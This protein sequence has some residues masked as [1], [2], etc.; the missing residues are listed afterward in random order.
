MANNIKKIKRID[1]EIENLKGHIESLKETRETMF[2]KHIVE[3]D[4][5]DELLT[6]AQAAR[7]FSKN[8]LTVRNLYSQKLDHLRKK[9]EER[10]YRISYGDLKD[11][12]QVNTPSR[13]DHVS[14]RKLPLLNAIEHMKSEGM[15]NRDIAAVLDCSL[16]MVVRS[17]AEIKRLNRE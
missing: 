3:D 11:H 6:P 8:S 10:V 7:V 12:F 14:S 2:L 17:N 16:S 13:D 5:V 4:M 15:L 9:D 1:T